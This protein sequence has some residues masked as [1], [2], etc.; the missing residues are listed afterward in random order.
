MIS[1]GFRDRVV[2]TRFVIFETSLQRARLSFGRLFS[3]LFLSFDVIS[4]KRRRV[5]VMDA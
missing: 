2:G 1:R 5:E 4:N 3:F